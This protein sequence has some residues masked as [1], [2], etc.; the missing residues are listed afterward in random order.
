ML[1]KKDLQN[2]EK[3]IAKLYNDGVIKAPI[4]LVDNNE[5]QLIEVFKNYYKE[6]D[7][8]LSTWRSHLHWLLSGRS[9][10]KLKKQILDG[11]SMSVF[12]KD[13]ITSSIVGGIVPI[14]VGIAMG[15]KLKK[16]KNKVMCFLGDASFECGISKESIRYAEGHDLPILFIIEN[17]ARCVRANTQEVWGRKNSKKVIKYDYKPTYPHAGCGTYCQF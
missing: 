5:E 11:Y 8:I 15:L 17:N 14:A 4:H 10:E 6:G 16:S 7:V 3:E 13:F 2:F 12:D 1:N 9:P